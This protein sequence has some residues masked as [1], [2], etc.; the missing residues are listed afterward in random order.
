MTQE[1]LFDLLKMY[2]KKNELHVRLK[3]CEL[4]IEHDLE[5][6]YVHSSNGMNIPISSLT[7]EEFKKLMQK[8]INSITHELNIIT[9]KF[10]KA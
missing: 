9:L 1:K 4:M 3:K 2:D 10:E 8:E 6:A 7:N 5:K